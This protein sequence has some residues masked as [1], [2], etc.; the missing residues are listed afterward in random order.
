MLSSKLIKPVQEGRVILFIRGKLVNKGKKEAAT[1]T[2]PFFSPKYKAYE[3]KMLFFLGRLPQHLGI[4]L[5]PDEFYEF[6]AYF[7]LPVRAA[8]YPLC[9]W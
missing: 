9:V 4:I 2:P 8:K 6:A 1:S 5:S 3:S 7:I